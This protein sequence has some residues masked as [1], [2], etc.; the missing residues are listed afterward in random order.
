MFSMH[1]SAISEVLFKNSRTVESM[2]HL[3]E[4]RAYVMARR[5]GLYPEAIRD[6][7]APVDGVLGFTDCN[8]IAEYLP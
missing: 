6:K 7:C 5:A 4:L 8:K 1:T 2:G 3:L